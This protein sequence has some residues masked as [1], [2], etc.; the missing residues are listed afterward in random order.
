VNTSTRRTLVGALL[1]AAALLAALWLTGASGHART[2]ARHTLL[3]PPP[4]AEP[5]VPTA[6]PVFRAT[7]LPRASKTPTAASRPTVTATQRSD[8]PPVATKLPPYRATALP[9]AAASATPTVGEQPSTTVT[10]HADGLLTGSNR[11]RVG[12]AL[13]LG[14]LTDYD[15]DG[16]EP[17]W[18]LNWQVDPQPSRVGRARFAQ[19]VRVNEGGF[20][21]PLDTI[22]RAAQANPGSLWLIGNEP[23]VKWQDNVTPE[24]YAA[25]YGELHQAIKAAD[26]TAQVAIGGVSQPT[27]LRMAYLDRVLAA[28]RTQ[29]GAE[30]PV[31]VWNVHAFILREEQGSWG[32]DIPPGMDV[33]QGQLYEIADHND[34]EVFRRQITDFRRWMAERG[35]RDKPLIV[36]EYGIL[37]PASYGFPPEVVSDFL[38]NTFDFFLTARDAELG[39][40]A[41]DDRLVQA[42]NWFSIA[43]K[44]Y[45][46]SNLFDPETRNVSPTGETFKAYVSGLR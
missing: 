26:P 33:A 1:L 45:P 41:D 14:K 9:T 36:T 2:A 30:M 29:F 37:M 18:Y 24:R 10:P 20:Y 13:A 21:P 43:D 27:P 19:M 7:A 39:Y 12:A 17:G 4:T 46:T 28:Y 34:M 38:V 22:R 35:L 16:A 25:V 11:A 3:K 5:L 8:Q 31:D 23:D 6:L 42:F 44:T 40:P 15:W 32:V